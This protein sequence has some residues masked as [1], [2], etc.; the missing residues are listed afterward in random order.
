MVLPGPARIHSLADRADFALAMRG[1]AEKYRPRPA[2]YVHK[3]RRLW[4]ANQVWRA[5]ALSRRF[6]LFQRRN[7]AA[8]LIWARAS[9]LKP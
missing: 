2:R 9:W 6:A 7:C 8:I 4:R 1:V 5:I 3:I